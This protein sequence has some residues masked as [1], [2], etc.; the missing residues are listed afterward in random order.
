MKQNV[1]VIGGGLAGTEAAWQ[2]AQRGH[3]V[4]LYEMRPKRTTGAHVTNNLGEL[5]CSNSLGSKL[6]DRAT[7]VLQNEMK[8]LDSLLIECAEE[9]AV[10][11]GGA[12]AVDREKFA[13][14]VTERIASHPNIEVFR[15]EVTELNLDIPTIVCTGPLTSPALAEKIAQL[16]GQD[17]LYFYDA[18]SPIVVAESINMDIAFHANRY[19]RGDNP[20]GDYINCPMEKDQYYAFVNALKEA[21]TIELRDFEREDP[22]FFEGCIPIEQLAKRG[23]D[24]LAYGPMRPVGITNP[25]TGKRPYAVVQLRRDNLAGSLY[26]IVGFQTNVRWGQQKEVLNLI[27][28]LED[29]EYIRFGQMHRNTF[30]NAPTLLKPT[31]QFRAHEKLYFG[32]QITGVEGYVGNIATGLIAAINLSRTLANESEWVPGTETMVGALCH[33]VTHT[34]P[35][36]FQP[37]KANFGILPPLEQK[38]KGKRQRKQAYADRAQQAMEQSVSTLRRVHENRIQEL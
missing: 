35:K 38:I 34:E 18:I 29:A 9:S 24:T 14:L 17:Y 20:E 6:P 15:E 30:I 25:H 1:V 27:P 7:G 37:M 8:M 11:A 26:N 22:N 32:G 31:M 5:V 12:L 10:A 33:Y 36:D 3:A 4:T 13:E 19:D 16:T 28:G 21:E 23:D 2:L